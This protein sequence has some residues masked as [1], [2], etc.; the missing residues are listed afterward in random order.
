MRG[1]LSPRALF[2]I[3]AAALAATAGFF[4]QPLTADRRVVRTA[5]A[6]TEDGELFKPIAKVLRDPRCMNCHPVGDRPRQGDNRHF[7]LQNVTR[8]L[9]DMGFVNLRCSACHRDEN[10]AYSGLPGAPNWHLAPLSMGW[11]GLNDAQLCTV[12]KDKSKNGG[13]DVAALIEHMSS[14]KLVLWGWN[15]GGN[16]KPVSTPHDKFVEQLHAWQAADAPCPKT[17]TP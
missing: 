17:A 2:P 14:D 11:E 5:L 16:R 7:H 12:L 10:N 3:T 8:G 9:D 6:A 13:R 1:R 15:P 4:L